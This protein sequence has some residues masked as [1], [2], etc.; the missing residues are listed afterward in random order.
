MQLTLSDLF[1]RAFQFFE[2]IEEEWEVRGGCFLYIRGMR[3]IYCEEL[4]N[5][6]L[7]NIC[8]ILNTFVGVVVVV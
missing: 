3:R 1:A 6:S 5:P 2:K 7:G 8:C 4:Q